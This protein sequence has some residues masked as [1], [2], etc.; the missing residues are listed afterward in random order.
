MVCLSEADSFDGNHIFQRHFVILWEL[1]SSLCEEA[2]VVR[3]ISCLESFCSSWSAKDDQ[4]QEMVE[5]YTSATGEATKD[6]LILYH[7]T[8]YIVSFRTDHPRAQRILVAPC[9]VGLNNMS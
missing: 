8:P 6:C 4:S 2:S 9:V 7:C 5:R 3:F 1:Y